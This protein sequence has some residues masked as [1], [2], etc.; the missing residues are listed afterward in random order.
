MAIKKGAERC[1]NSAQGYFAL[2]KK[3]GATDDD[4]KRAIAAAF[5]HASTTHPVHMRGIQVAD[6]VA[7]KTPLSALVTCDRDQSC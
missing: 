7:P 2:A 1:D 3:H 6:E 4:I 5:E